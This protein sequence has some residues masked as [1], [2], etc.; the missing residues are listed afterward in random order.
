MASLPGVTTIINDRFYAL[1][2]TNIPTGSRVLAI[3]T[4]DT[5]DGTEDVPDLAPYVATS[6]KDVIA[7]FGEG[8]QL[9]KAYVELLSGGAPQVILIPLPSDTTFTNNTAAI[10]SASYTGEDLWDDLWN[11]VETAQPDIVVPWGRGGGPTDWESPATPGN[12][13]IGFYANNSTTLANSWIKKVADKVSAI[14]GRSNPCFAVLGVAPFTTSETMTTANVIT[15]LNLSNLIDRE[16]DLFETGMYVSVVA[17]ELR[18]LGYPAEWGWS[19]G[20]CYYAGA[21]SKLDPQSSP[22]GKAISRVERLRYSPGRTVQSDLIDLG[23]VPVGV[24]FQRNPMWV[25]SMTFTKTG[26]DFRRLTTLRIAFD[27]IQVVR[28]ASRQFIGEAS[29]LLSRNSM[30][31]A[32]TAG[33]RN[34]QISG[35]LLASDFTLTFIGVENKARVD[36]ILTPAFEM[37]EIEI[38]VSVQL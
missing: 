35:A 4:R 9:H 6:E 27:A 38:S 5:D 33:L 2:R 36:L 18:P 11:E 13:T 1:T 26:S 28:Q 22:T 23:V 7:A 32:I 10:A 3:G 20:A 15:H 14:S 19:N 29:S 24:D 16:D 31:T 8:S 12:D 25:D 37:R 34:M 30:E 17:T 21:I